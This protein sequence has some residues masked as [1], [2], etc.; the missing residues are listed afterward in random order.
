MLFYS[1]EFLFVFLPL[2]LAGFFVVAR[3]SRPAA[4]GWLA[5]CSLVFYG[6]WNP[7]FTILL[8]GSIVLN[9]LLG[10]AIARRVGSAAARRLLI[11]GVVIDLAIL[12]Y[13][14][15]TNFFI[16]TLD[17]VF[18]THWSEVQVL[19]PLGISVF[20]FTQIAFLVDVYRGIAREYHL[21]K[22]GLFVA[23]FPHLI[24]GPIIHHA[25]F[26]PQMDD[27][28]T[29][30][31]RIENF[32]VGLCTFAIGMAKKVLLAGSFAEY[33]DPIFDAT[34][35]GLAPGLVLSWVA[36]LA[37]TLQI[38]FDFSGYTDMAIGLSRMFGIALP[39]NFD[40]PYKSRNVVEFWRRWN[41]TLSHFLRDYL[42]I[43]LGGNRHGKARRYLNLA[44]TMLLGGLWHGA[45]W[46]FVLWG[47]IHAAYLSFNHA[48]QE[49]RGR[50]PRLPIP[51][52]VAMGFTFLA[53]L[54][55]W[56]PFRAAT[57]DGAGRMLSGLVSLD[58]WR[59]FGRLGTTESE[60]LFN[61][62]WIPYD[63]SGYRIGL[64]LLGLA[65]VWLMPNT[66]ELMESIRK[67][68][69]KLAATVV[70]CVSFTV[71]LL[72][73]LAS[74]RKMGQFIYFNF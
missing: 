74:T 46:T 32:S 58:Q 14:K 37:Y 24:A 57:L 63:G 4:I 53:V 71:I 5:L 68:S 51:R 39:E 21:V 47:G 44:L 31:P 16:A 34:D 13:F 59:D 33:A 56:I 49:L 10:R 25:Q 15:Y 61:A 29:Y 73:L 7:R 30:R 52:A 36:A 27:P 40:S 42:Y 72:A 6:Y 67:A 38:Y 65:I 3:V 2:A 28:S 9:C 18:S 50:A 55:A 12:G 23:Y 26:M 43:P 19:L 11:I 35:A 17:G 20:T 64:F 1:Y 45:N 8:I 60:Y 48:I 62:V 69:P 66:R 22:Y 41:M 70:G 54:V